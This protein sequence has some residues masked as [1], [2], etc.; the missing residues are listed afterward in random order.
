M[1]NPFL[2][3]AERIGEHVLEPFSRVDWYIQGW[4]NQNPII[5]GDDNLIFLYDLEA[6]IL[7][8]FDANGYLDHRIMAVNQVDVNIIQIKLSLSNT[9]Q[10]TQYQ[11]LS[12]EFKNQILQLVARH[13][14]THSRLSKLFNQKLN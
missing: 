4:N 5:Y 2:I 1:T 11:R 14:P 8:S 10:I 13:E 3:N 12:S 6:K 7:H 9:I